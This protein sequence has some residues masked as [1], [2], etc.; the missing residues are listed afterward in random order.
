MSA[1]YARHDDVGED[2]HIFW[3]HLKHVDVLRQ[4]V[5]KQKNAT[6]SPQ[7]IF[8]ACVDTVVAA[9][10]LKVLLGK[11]NVGDSGFYPESKSGM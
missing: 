6:S 11:K 1:Q 4:C 9:G 8:S 10:R 3:C 7:V 2:M 5:G